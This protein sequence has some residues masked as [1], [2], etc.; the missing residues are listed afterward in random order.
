ME[1]L[2]AKQNS[3]SFSSGWYENLVR[4]PEFEIENEIS[5]ARLSISS[6]TD[7]SEINFICPICLC[8]KQD[9]E[10]TSFPCRHK[11]C[12]DCVKNYVRH[13]IVNGT[14]DIKCPVRSFTQPASSSSTSDTLKNAETQTSPEKK[15][16]IISPANAKKPPTKKSKKFKTSSKSSTKVVKNSNSSNSS[17]AIRE[18]V[19]SN[20]NNQTTNT[21]SWKLGPSAIAKIL[22]DEPE[23]VDRYEKFQLT[24]ALCRIPNIV[25]CPFPDCE[26]SVI[27]N[28]KMKKCPK[29]KCLKCEFEFCYT[30]RKPWGN[31]KHVDG[32]K[33][34]GKYTATDVLASNLSPGTENKQRKVSETNQSKSSK[35]QK[36][37]SAKTKHAKTKTTISKTTKSSKHH[38]SSK[39]FNPSIS[40]RNRTDSK[41]SSSS[42][43]THQINVKSRLKLSENNSISS[44]LIP[45]F[46]R[47]SSSQH[48]EKLSKGNVK[49]CPRCKA[50]ISKLDDGSC[51]HMY[52]SIC[53][54]SFCW[55]CLREVTDIGEGFRFTRKHDKITP[56]SAK[57]TSKESRKY[58]PS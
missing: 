28:P 1:K 44:E 33:C 37:E 30:C 57:R 48:S 46:P 58:F 55:L 8:N 5:K 31:G 54:C 25:H 19:N 6:D 7:R 12:K 29:I 4:S 50:L 3:L 32:K 45:F 38:P 36:N 35:N 21:C 52:C 11:V 18:S 56:K 2:S 10:L 20:T 23:I 15:D 26:Y 34:G 16:E 53:K 43:S 17:S 51:N 40:L 14:S 42:N 22:E 9:T 13:Q 47:D 41:L 27:A 49:P 24:K 39:K